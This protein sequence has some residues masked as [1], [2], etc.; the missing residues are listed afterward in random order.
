MVPFRMNVATI[1]RFALVLICPP[2]SII[3]SSNMGNASQKVLPVLD[4]ALPPNVP[5]RRN[6]PGTSKPR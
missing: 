6:R 3:E 4:T 1:Q 5:G 2:D